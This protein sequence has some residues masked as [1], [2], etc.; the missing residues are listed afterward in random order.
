MYYYSV[1]EVLCSIPYGASAIVV[2]P[3]ICSRNTKPFPGELL[4]AS[5]TLLRVR[6]GMTMVTEIVDYNIHHKNT[7]EYIS[8]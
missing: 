5:I 1:K 7:S 3:A 4:L 6:R 8:K 2:D